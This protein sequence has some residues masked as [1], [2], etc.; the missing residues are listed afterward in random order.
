M[1]TRKSA[2]RLSSAYPTSDE[3]ARY[4]R[5]ARR[6]RAEF[7]AYGAAS[8]VIALDRLVRRIACRI[9]ARLFGSDCMHAQRMGHLVPDRQDA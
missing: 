3:L 4:D 1:N 9:A 6:L 7:I 2:T 8:L 5:E